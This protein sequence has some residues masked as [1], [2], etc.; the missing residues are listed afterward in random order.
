[1]HTIQMFVPPQSLDTVHRELKADLGKV[2]LI[3]RHQL[4]HT[5]PSRE[6]VELREAISL[7]SIMKYAGCTE[8]VREDELAWALHYARDAYHRAM[9]FASLDVFD[10]AA[11]ILALACSQPQPIPLD[12]ARRI[13]N[14]LA[15]LA[16]RAQALA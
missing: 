14:E 16:P 9:P 13:G 5:A 11:E 3:L 2:L 7:I 10:K 15:L 1:M 8:L 4:G 12:L 6:Y